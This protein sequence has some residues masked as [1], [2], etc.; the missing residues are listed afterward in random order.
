MI[1]KDKMW[2]RD[3]KA[4]Y[5]TAGRSFTSTEEW[6]IRSSINEEDFIHTMNMN[7]A[8]KKAAYIM[9]INDDTLKTNLSQ[10]YESNLFAEI[11]KHYYECLQE[12]IDLSRPPTF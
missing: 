10:L 12:G 1:S 7:V 5:N 4:A 9:Q 11:T 3:V 2:R 8:V 6:F